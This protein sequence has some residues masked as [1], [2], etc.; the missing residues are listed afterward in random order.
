[1]SSV[2]TAN[3]TL[4]I[5]EASRVFAKPDSLKVAL[6]ENPGHQ[7]NQGR[8]AISLGVNPIPEAPQYCISVLK[9]R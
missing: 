7:N 5:A 8:A 6:G 3:E 9:S 1:M 4:S 2:T